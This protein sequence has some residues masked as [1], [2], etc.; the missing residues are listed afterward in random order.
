MTRRVARKLGHLASGLDLFASLQETH[1][2]VVAARITRTLY[3]RPSGEADV[4]RWPEFAAPVTIRPDPSDR[5]TF[6]HVVLDRGYALPFDVDPKVIVDAGANIGL[7][8][9]WFATQ[10]PRARILA[11]EPEPENH[12]LLCANVAAH[13]N[14]TPL[15]MALSDRDGP[16]VLHDPGMGPD[17]YRIDHPETGPASPD[18][19]EDADPSADPGAGP[20]DAVE[21]ITLTSLLDRFGVDEVDVLKLDIEGSEIEVLSSAEE[22]AHRVDV[23]A[24]ELHD[25]F[26][27]GCSRAF[28]AAIADR[29]GSQVDRGEDV[30][31]RRLAPSSPPPG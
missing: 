8:S 16:V 22:W 9:V 19:T 27:P 11:L 4:V 6:R 28:Y 21:G 29:F 14:V 1:G 3:R 24:I 20:A 26:R 30:F 17:G 15:A 5:F 13:P 25:R 10:Y 7:A 18:A 12:R 31:V 23:I 2:T